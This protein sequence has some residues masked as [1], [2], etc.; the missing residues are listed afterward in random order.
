MRNFLDE[1][2]FFIKGTWKGESLDDVAMEVPEYLQYLLDE[3][4]LDAVERD[5]IEDALIRYQ[6]EE[7]KEEED[8]DEDE[9]D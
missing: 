3:H 8:E 5:I 7:Y 6:D 2:Q 4:D 1:D 9:D